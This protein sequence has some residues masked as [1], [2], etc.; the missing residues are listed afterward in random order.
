MNACPSSP[1]RRQR[2]VSLVE[3][4]VTMVVLAFGLLGLAAFQ[5]KAQVGSIESYQRAQAA[6]LLQDM[7]SRLSGNLADADSYV[8]TTPLGTSDTLGLDCGNGAAGATRDKCEWSAALKG[9]AEKRGNVLGGAMQGARGCVTRVQ[10]KNEAAGV[11]T[12]AIYQ[13]SV[14]WQGMHATRP[15]AAGQ[16]CAIGAYGTETHRRVISARVAVGLPTCV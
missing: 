5:T 12:P 6:V 1:S 14:A 11:C 4:L 7:Q 15:P 8:T 2:G 9:A 10:V 16:A 3:V 13:V